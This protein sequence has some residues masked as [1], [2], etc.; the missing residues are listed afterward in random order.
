[1]KVMPALA[2]SEFV[3]TRPAPHL[4]PVVAA[5][6]FVFVVLFFLNTFVTS[7]P[8]EAQARAYFSAKEIEDGLRFA[9]ERKLIFWS[10]TAASLTLWTVVVLAGWGRQLADL[11]GRLT[12][13]RWLLTVLGVG[14]ACFLAQAVLA[15]PFGLL[16]LEENRAWGMTNRSVGD[17]LS[18]FGKGLAVTAITGTV[19]LVGFYLLIRY[20]PRWWWFLATAVGLLLGFAYAYLM[21]ILIDPLFHHFHPLEDAGLRAKVQALAARAGVP[22]S[23]VLVM[24]AS[25]TGRHT[26][27]YFTGFGPTRRIVL[28]DTL[29]KNHS[30][31]EIESI[32]GHEIGHWQHNHIVKGI[33]LA[34]AGACLGLFLLAQI[35][36]WAVRRKPFFLLAPADPAG[37]PLILLLL[38]VGSWLALPVQN[39]VSRHFERQAD[40]AAL[41]LADHPDAFIAAEKRM[42]QEN[43]G[44]VAPN[45]VSVWLFATHPPVLERIEMAE[46]WK[47]THSK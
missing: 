38:E 29:L 28:Y 37:L 35:L 36:R 30:P 6:A 40:R 25:R 9:F 43:I 10:A 16:G 41:Q 34:A 32:L 13:G 4:L 5:G 26:N 45:P 18:D 1:V 27:A 2:Q 21:P 42:A 7:A 46:E 31:R 19:L 3:A 44:N 24:D 33:L 17:W 47:R 23:D 11:A 20:F 14:A 15:L 8:A 12:G 22:V 39:A